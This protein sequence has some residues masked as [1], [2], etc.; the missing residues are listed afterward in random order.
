MSNTPPNYLGILAGIGQLPG[1]PSKWTRG[2][3]GDIIARCDKRINVLE[4]RIGGVTLGRVMPD[5]DQVTIGSGKHFNLSVL[6]LDICDFSS[7]PNWT[8]EEQKNILVLM[9]IFMA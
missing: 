5:L 8:A 3:V 9:N 7:R 6:F 4:D 1:T 2:Y